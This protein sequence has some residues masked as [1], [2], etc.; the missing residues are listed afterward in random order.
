MANS[1]ESKSMS[2]EEQA[3]CNLKSQSSTHPVTKILRMLNY[4]KYIPVRGP[5][6]R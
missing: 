5:A 3:L 2:L 4:L 1:L 6:P